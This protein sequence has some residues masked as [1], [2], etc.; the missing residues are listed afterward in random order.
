MFVKT[1]GA[2]SGPLFESEHFTSPKPAGLHAKKTTRFCTNARYHR[3]SWVTFLRP[4]VLPEK[5]KDSRLGQV[6]SGRILAS[7]MGR[8]PRA[9]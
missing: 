5:R 2:R 4:N 9:Y 6:S 7:K 1:C 3:N 8:G